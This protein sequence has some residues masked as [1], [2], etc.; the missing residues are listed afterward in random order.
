M[1]YFTANP[2]GEAETIK[3][4]LKPTPR[5]KN[6]VIDQDFSQILIKGRQA[7]GNILTKFPIHRITLKAHGVSTLGGR[8]VWFDEDVRRLNYDGHGKH[9]GEFLDGELILVVLE[10]GDFYTT[11]F[12]TNNHYDDNIRVIEKFD[13]HKV[14]TAVLY[15]ESQKG[16][17]YVKRFNFE[18]TNRKQNY[19]G[20]NPGNRLLL[21]S[22]QYYARF[23]VTFGGGDAFRGK[24]EVD[25][26]EFIAIKGYKAKGKRLTTYTIKSVKELEPTRFPEPPAAPAPAAEPTEVEDPDADKSQ[27]DILDEL[28]GQM[29]LF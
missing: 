15:D 6:L 20:D 28:T 10:N 21:L 1:L 7:M 22:D 5:L 18:A 4:T 11:D 9:L 26:D 29:K 19:L 2:N 25:A 8:E 23:L 12:D 13:P 27:G 17:P 24:I 16:F 14:W 3:V